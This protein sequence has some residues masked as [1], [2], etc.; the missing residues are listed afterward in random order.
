MFAVVDGP[1]QLVRHTLLQKIF[2]A[3][4]GN[5]DPAVSQLALSAL[6]KFKSAHLVSCSDNLKDFF[7]KGR[8][9]NAML[10]LKEDIESGKISEEHRQ[11][12]VPL[13]SRILFGRL[14]AKGAKS[15]KDSP[16]ARRAA[17]VAFLS[18]LCKSDTEL[19]SLVYLMA[20]AFIP[21]DEGLKA[22]ET[23]DESDRRQILKLLLS[24]QTNN[25]QEVPAHSTAGFLHLLETVVSQLGHRLVNFVPHFASIIVGLCKFAAVQCDAEDGKNGDADLIDEKVQEGAENEVDVAE[26][27][28]DTVRMSSIRTLCYNRLSELFLQF[29]GSIDFSF[30]SESL[31]EALENSVKLLPEMVVKSEKSPALL[32]LLH[33]LS[34]EPQLFALL[35]VPVDPASAVMKC[36]QVTSQASVINTTLS[37][38]ENLLTLEDT[39]G[40]SQTYSTGRC[41]VQ[42]HLPLLLE[43][44]ASRLTAGGPSVSKI[45]QTSASSKGRPLGSYNSMWR[46]ELRILLLVSEAIGDH[47]SSRLKEKSIVLEQ[48]CTLLL[49]F[50]DSGKQVHADDRMNVIGI[51]KGILSHL[52]KEAIQ[53]V[54]LQLSKSLSPCNAKIGIESLQVRESVAFLFTIVGN[55]DRRFKSVA[56]VINQLAAVHRKRVDEIDFEAII[57]VLNKLSSTSEDCDWILLG[58]QVAFDRTLISPIINYCFHFLHINDAVISRAAFNALKSVLTVA[59]ARRNRPTESQNKNEDIVDEWDRLL[60][61]SIIPLVKAGLH[62]R[63]VSVRRYYVLLVREIAMK[64]EGEASPHLLG[65]LGVLCNDDNL[66]LDFFVNITHVQIHRRARGLTRLRK[67]I[68]E[69]LGNESS[70][71]LVPSSVSNIILPLIMHPVFECDTKAEETYALEAIATIG[72]IARCLPWKKYHAT[73]WT[74]LTQFDRH[75][76]RERYMLGLLCALIDGFHFELMSTPVESDAVSPKGKTSVWRALEN[77]VI[78][79]I[80]SLLTKENVDKKGNRVKTIRAALLLALLKLY[81]RFPESFFES[82]LSRILAVVCDALASKD[83][84]VRDT[85]RNTLGKIVVSMDLKYLSD[86]IREVTIT[87]HEGYKLHVRAATIHTILQMLSAAYTGP[88][89]DSDG[90]KLYFDKCVPALM[91]VIQDDLFGEANE[92]RESRETNVRYVKEAGGTKSINSVEIVCRMIKF[93]PSDANRLMSVSSVHCVVSPFLERLRLPDVDATTIKKVREILSRVVVGLSNNSSVESVELLPFVFATLQPFIDAE[94][95]SSLLE[96]STDLDDDDDFED[97]DASIRISGSGQGKVKQRQ[98]LKTPVVEWRPSILGASGTARDA[99]EKK[100]EGA[101]ELVKVLDGASAPKLTGTGRH[102]AVSGNALKSPASIS[103]VVFGLNLLNSNLKSIQTDAEDT[104]LSMMDPFV[105]LLTACVCHSN[106]VDV[107]VVAFKCILAL[108]RFELPAFE[109]YSKLLGPKTLDFLTSS[110]SSLNQNQDLI[111]A[112]FKTL[113]Y[114]IN[115][116][117]KIGVNDTVTKNTSKQAS[118]ED[119]LASNIVMPLNSEQMKVLITTIQ[120]SLAE[121]EQHNPALALIKAIMSRKYISPEFYDLMDSMLELVVRS[122][123]SSLRQVSDPNSR[124]TC[125]LRSPRCSPLISVYKT[126][127]VGGS[128]FGSCLTFRCTKGGL[129]SI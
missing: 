65:D 37:F 47:E 19:F 124:T 104:L 110:G 17:I 83:S 55:T 14:T 101:K 106:D 114:L 128:L 89:Q 4:L 70:P 27:R 51:L 96:K 75:P 59:S 86:V 12:L 94:K 9:R 112:C 71:P 53:P 123:K 116:D 20:R 111:Q 30:L 42:K 80:E 129:N 18:S 24:I 32:T 35:D 63:E 74:V 78:P 69:T 84:D 102:G 61:G 67:L 23:Q 3:F 72:A 39:D 115:T 76:S 1:K 88:S 36:I 16:A 54:F 68:N 117:R 79:K 15:A 121:S 25:L 45:V 108:L 28:H 40:D 100:R 60:E 21:K 43:R 46:R 13:L 50:L 98:S 29:G 118:G 33:T 62:C 126:S 82:R 41:L 26:A 91:N 127:K 31:W 125:H 97:H 52:D 64:F 22:I 5:Q 120:V 56:V 113:A 58:T 57:P 6:M 8:L 99:T 7:Q 90:E 66:D 119:A 122:Q 81:Q 105:S 2:T 107:L 48:L 109:S 44:F 93:K 77:R 95:I 38:I 87:L 92:R 85:A 103:A 49:V 73:L 34:T 10:N 11:L